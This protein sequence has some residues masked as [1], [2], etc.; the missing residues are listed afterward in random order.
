MKF[1]MVVI[2]CF[3]LDCNAIWEQTWYPTIEDCK[4]ASGTVKEFMITTY[5]N[6]A[7]QIWCMNEEEFDEYYKYLENGGKPT[8]ES[9][10]NP[11]A[12]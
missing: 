9:L 5:P 6:S 11:S 1:I 7:G 3:S 8:L 12:I 2:V 10:P 4:E